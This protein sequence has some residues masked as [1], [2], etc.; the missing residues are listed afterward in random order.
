MYCKTASKLEKYMRSRPVLRI[1]N[2]F[3]SDLDPYPTF[4]L[5]LDPDLDS[6]PDHNTLVFNKT[7]VKILDAKSTVPTYR[8]QQPEQNVK[9]KK[10]RCS[11]FVAKYMSINTGSITKCD[12]VL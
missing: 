10:K 3:L 8:T 4:K 1:R 7:A 2:Y 11:L 9:M 6:F 5:I 12:P